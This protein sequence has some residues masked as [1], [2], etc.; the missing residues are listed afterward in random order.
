MVSDNYMLLQGRMITVNGIHA[1]A[2][3]TLLTRGGAGMTGSPPSG[4]ESLGIVALD[5]L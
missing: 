2:A 3:V 5:R 4:S 1:A